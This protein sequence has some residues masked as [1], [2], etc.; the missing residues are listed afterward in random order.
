M[1]WRASGPPQSPHAGNRPSVIP[2]RPAERHHLGPKPTAAPSPRGPR[3]AGDRSRPGAKS[4]Y[5]RSQVREAQGFDKRRA[6]G[7]DWGT[8]T[9]CDLIR[10]V[11]HGA[12]PSAAVGTRIP[13]AAGAPTSPDRR[14]RG[15]PRRRFRR[16]Q[17][18]VRRRVSADRPGR[19]PH[20]G[21][22]LAGRTGRTF[23]CASTSL[24]AVDQP[25][26][27]PMARTRT[28]QAEYSDSASW[29]SGPC[30]RP[31]RGHRHRGRDAA[32]PRCSP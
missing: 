23:G 22:A 15:P 19:G 12:Y 16:L 2:L 32:R 31:A 5:V 6:A 27:G 11:G 8:T 3:N 14:R 10:P 21:G 29:P 17:Q 13:S 26:E 25:L 24:S 4:R 30:R 20:S 18:S 28:K 9:S 1:L 7:R